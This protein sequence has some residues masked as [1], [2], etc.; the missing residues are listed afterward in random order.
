MQTYLQCRMPYGQWHANLMDLSIMPYALRA[1]L[2]NMMVLFAMRI[3][4][5]NDFD[6]LKYFS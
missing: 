6:S 4:T 1:M 5:G 2:S 3:Y